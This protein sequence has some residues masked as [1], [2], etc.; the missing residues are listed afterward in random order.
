MVSSTLEVVLMLL[1]GVLAAIK[2]LPGVQTA[3][4]ALEAAIAAVA[5]VQNDPVVTKAGLE[6]LRIVLP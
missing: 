5:S 4:A 3:I 1:S 6:G 2:P